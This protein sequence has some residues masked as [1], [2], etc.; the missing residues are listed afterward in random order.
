MFTAEL[1]TEKKE[2][3]QQDSFSIRF[4]GIHACGVLAFY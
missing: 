4:P 1:Y 2:A 3:A